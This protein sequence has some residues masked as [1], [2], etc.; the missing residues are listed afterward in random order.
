MAIDYLKNGGIP[1]L[2]FNDGASL[3]CLANDLGYENVFARQIDMHGQS[4]DLLVAISSSGR[5]PSILNGVASARRQEMDVITLSGFRDDNPL[6]CGG[7]RNF[8]VK[9]SEYGFVEI[10]HLIICHAFLDMTLGWR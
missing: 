7:D 5:S 6:R 3:T 10:S 1:A 4:G 2:A 8:Y 9:S